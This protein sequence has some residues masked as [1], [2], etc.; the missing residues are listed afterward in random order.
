MWYFLWAIGS[1]VNMSFING[2][3]NISDI[4]QFNLPSLVYSSN[5]DYGER[6]KKK[7]HK[8]Q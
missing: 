3:K 1:C 4:R 8:G 6:A 5:K 7:K 2:L